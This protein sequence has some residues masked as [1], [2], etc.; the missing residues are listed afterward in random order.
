MFFL[1]AIKCT[2][3]LFS[4]LSLT[5]PSYLPQ[6]LFQNDY[7]NKEEEMSEATFSLFKVPYKDHHQCSSS[8]FSLLK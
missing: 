7:T 1:S 8:N 3:N 5:P 4:S 6:I 2:C